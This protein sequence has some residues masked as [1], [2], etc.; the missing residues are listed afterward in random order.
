LFKNDTR[1]A[2]TLTGI[3]TV[4]RKRINSR[5]R[6][7]TKKK[8][9]QFEA[10]SKNLC[11]L[12]S[13]KLKKTKNKRKQIQHKTEIKRPKNYNNSNKSKVISKI[14]FNTASVGKCLSTHRRL[15]L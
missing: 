12:L 14:T 7:N 2:E 6:Q 10:S 8:E 4:R 9:E 15:Y 5:E 3:T 1:Q 11:E 13:T